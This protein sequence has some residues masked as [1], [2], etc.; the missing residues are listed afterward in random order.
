MSINILDLAKTYI[1]SSNVEKLSGLLGENSNGVQSAIG[2]ILPSVLG[3]IMQKASTTAGAGEIFDLVRENGNSGLLDGLS[4]VLGNS[5]ESNNLFSLGAKILPTLFGNK[6]A[7]IAH[8]VSS[9]SGIKSS[10]ATSLLSFAAPL[11]L[12]LLGNQ[13]K[14]SGLGLSGLTSMLM[15]QKD[16]VLSALPAGL[17]RVLNFADLGDFKGSETPKRESTT[18]SVPVEKEESGSPKWLMWVLLALIA[19]ALIWAMKT[20]KKDD[21]NAVVEST[22]AS[23]DSANAAVSDMVDSTQSKVSAG[24]EALGTFFKKKLPN[25]IELDIP[26]FGIENKLVTFIEDT[27]LPVDK[28]TWFNFDRINFE[29]GSAK[30]SAE[31]LVQTKN[32]AEILKAFPKV[33]LKVGGYTDNTGDAALNLKLSGDRAKAVKEAIVAEGIDAK[34]LDAEG[35]GKEHPVASNDTEEGRAQNRRIAVRVT[36]K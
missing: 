2:S 13:V 30:L 23:L 18:Y 11:V 20:C 9:E 6:T 17:G 4:S 25:G 22:E 27:K 19:A 24:L 28:T 14:S 16:A 12:S 7:D 34:R 8:A 32:I 33:S 26:E 5:S 1:T 35:Y 31:S 29:T 21:A 10:S 15:G 3:G 36:A